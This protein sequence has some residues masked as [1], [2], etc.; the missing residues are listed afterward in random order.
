MQTENFCEGVIDRL[1][2]EQAVLRLV[3]GQELV[4][5]V[6]KLPENGQAGDVVVLMVMS[7]TEATASH[8]AVAQEILNEI[9]VADGNS[10]GDRE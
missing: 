6:S 9:F 4:W 1:E 2:G 8:Q 3:D 10:Q 7:D 5:P